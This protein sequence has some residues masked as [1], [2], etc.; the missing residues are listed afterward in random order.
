MR[1]VSLSPSAAEKA[2]HRVHPLERQ[3]GSLR[4]GHPLNHLFGEAREGALALARP[5]TATRGLLRGLESCR[6]ADGLVI[7]APERDHHEASEQA[8]AHD[9]VD[10]REPGDRRVKGAEVLPQR[11]R[12]LAGFAPGES[13][14]DDAE[15]DAVNDEP[16]ERSPR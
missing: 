14:A 13:Q 9:A 15:P 1:F 6:G 5:W 2:L 8:G 16:E 12:D 10:Q 4:S 11:R 7:A 3:R